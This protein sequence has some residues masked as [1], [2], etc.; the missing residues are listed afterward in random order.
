MDT[1]YWGPTGWKLLH[2]IAHAAKPKDMAN[3]RAFFYSVAFVLPCKYCRKSFSEYITEDPMPHSASDLPKWLW[4]IHNDVNAK[5]RGQGLTVV[6]DPPFSSVKKT[7]EDLLSVGC[8]R[9]NFEGWEFLFSV[10]EAHPLSRNGKASIPIQDHPAMETLVEPLE[11]NRW[12]LM[13]PE[14]RLKFYNGFWHLLPGVLP[15]PEWRSIWKRSAKSQPTCRT[16]CLTH[17]WS[18]RRSL[19]KELELLNRTTYHSLCKEIK[20][21]R[22]NCTRS[23]RGKTCRKKRGPV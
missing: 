19:E 5:L 12:N 1:R 23:T 6:E 14:E 3:L 20:R 18:I 8:T 21:H 17:L 13:D 10:A 16:E 22:S 15:F 7:Y 2:L 4:R 11:R 9:T